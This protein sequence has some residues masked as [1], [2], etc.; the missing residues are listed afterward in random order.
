MKRRR[1]KH[2]MEST[3]TALEIAINNF[4]GI[5]DIV[6][7]SYQFDSKGEYKFKCL[8]LYEEKIN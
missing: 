3:S 7:I 1:V 8:V 5:V 6:Q 4:S 2:F